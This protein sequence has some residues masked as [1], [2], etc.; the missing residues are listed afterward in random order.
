M[1]DLGAGRG[2]DYHSW[3]GCSNSVAARTVAAAIA[4]GA[5][6]GFSVI[7]DS[8]ERRR[9]SARVLGRAL[10]GTS[11]KRAVLPLAK[12]AD[13]DATIHQEVLAIPYI[14][15]DDYENKICH[16]L[17]QGHPVLLVGPSM[18]GKTKMAARVIADHFGSWPAI[19]PDSK[20]VLATLDA[21][22]LS[23]QGC[24]VWLDDLNNLIGPAG[25]TPGALQLLADEGNAIIGTMRSTEYQRF[26]PTDQLRPPEWD[27]LSRFERIFVDRELSLAD[28]Q[29]LDLAV[30]DPAIRARIREIGIGEYVGAAVQVAEK[31]RLG[32][33]GTGGVGYALVLAV[34][35]WYRCGLSRP[36][37]ATLLPELAAAHLNPRGLSLLADPAGFR[38]GLTWAIRQI[39]PKVSLIEPAGNDTY[40]IY[41]YALD[42]L[43]L[44]GDPIPGP[45]WSRAI[46]EASPL[47]RATIGY[48]ALISNEEGHAAEALQ[49]AI[50]SGDSEATP[51]AAFYLGNLL[52]TYG[53]AKGVRRAFQIAIDSGNPEIAPR[54]AIGLGA[55]LYKQGDVEEARRLFQIGLDSGYLELGPEAAADLGFRGSQE[56]L[57]EA[58]QAYQSAINTDNTA[59]AAMAALNLGALLEAQGDAEGARQAYQCAIDSEQADAAPKAARRLGAL[60]EKDGD[61][62]GARQAFQIAIDSGHAEQAPQ[63]A[64]DLATLFLQQ[65]DMEGARQ[66][67]QIAIDSDDIS[68]ASDAAAGL[69]TILFQQG[70]LDGARQAYQI[71]I[72]A[73]D[74]STAPAAAIGLAVVLRQQGDMDG[75]RQAYQMAIDSGHAEAAPMAAFGLGEVLKKE[76]DAEKA[77]QAYQIAI[78]SGHPQ[79]GPSAV[80]SLGALLFE[81]GDTEEARHVF[82]VAVDSGYLEVTPEVAAELGLSGPAVVSEDASAEVK[83]ATPEDD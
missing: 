33:A 10:R 74:L 18:V 22:D 21:A 36:V 71:A 34:A 77:R 6:P 32:A 73:G 40:A 58:R 11:G 61:S 57:E 16:D 83:P 25:I 66:A 7:I 78:D 35:D 56:K 55:L 47:E 82:Q 17:R 72:D 39:N 9:T 52:V 1:A 46:S 15:R 23:P 81:Q 37:P 28:E 27:V 41:D 50:D 24:V 43:T 79:W 53:D 30:S 19:I 68:A 31:L 54:A 48:V 44:Q 76:G 75:A 45:T 20:A 13:L 14:H 26:Q 2:C 12:D 42:L 49:S 29:N 5:P 60:L 70:D 4:V 8:F 63:A 69:A 65:G 64:N 59:Q 3:G 67:F 51:V 62:D 38:D 80:V